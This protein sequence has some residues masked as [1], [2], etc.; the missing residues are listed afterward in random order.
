[1]ATRAHA[2][3]ADTSDVN[4][5][6]GFDEDA[7]YVTYARFW[8]SYDER[9]PKES[10]TLNDARGRSIGELEA[11]W[12]DEARMTR[13]KSSGTTYFD[14]LVPKRGEVDGAHIEKALVAAKKLTTT[15]KSRRVR[16]VKSDSTCG[17]IELETKS[18][19]L[20]VAEHEGPDYFDV[21][22]KYRFEA[23]EHPKTN[24]VFIRARHKSSNADH[25]TEIDSLT[26][27]PRPW[28]DGIELALRGERERLEGK[29][30]EAIAH[31]E[32]SIALAPG[33]LPSRVSLIRAY[34]KAKRKA[35]PLIVELSRPIPEGARMGS[36]PDRALVRR[37]FRAWPNAKFPETFPFWKHEEG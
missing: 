25:S 29:L 16:H 21:C 35:A 26:E 19:W 20:R 34:A 23:F 5:I 9:I 12:D 30:D 37:L 18:G 31:L 6:V 8:N 28:V 22:A 33:Y 15:T 7:R 24:V 32:K 4:R 1:M 17:S 14:G 11:V 3:N 36:P 13:W 10:F 2:C 27:L